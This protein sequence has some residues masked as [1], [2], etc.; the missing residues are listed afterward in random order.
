MADP[1]KTVKRVID[2]IKNKFILPAMKQNRDP[3]L[4]EVF[5]HYGK[6]INLAKALGVTRQAVSAWKHVPFRYV[7]RI[8]KDTNIPR[9]K[10]RPDIFGD[11]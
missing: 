6:S 3:I 8:A 5:Q 7:G 11:A 2:K 10:L 4:I 9:E 1:I